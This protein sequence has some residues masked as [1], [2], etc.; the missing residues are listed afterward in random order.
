MAKRRLFTGMLVGA[1][2][3]GLAA[4]FDRETREYTK[5]KL[6]NVKAGSSYLIK[7]PSDAVHK[8]RVAFDEFNT[9]ITSSSESAINAL[10][11]V[12]STLEKYTNK[13]ESSRI[14]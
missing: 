11:Q 1:V 4:L 7:N 5:G 13:E 3:G 10:E 9:K 6:K 2:A 14:E 8:V 12:E